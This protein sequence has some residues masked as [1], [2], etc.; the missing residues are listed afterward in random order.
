M[1]ENVPIYLITRWLSGEATPEERENLEIWLHQSPEN[2]ALFKEHETL[3]TRV[4]A[5]ERFK[6]DQ[7]LS[8]IN[9][10]I[11]AY[12]KLQSTSRSS[13]PFLLYKIAA[14]LIAV[15]LVGSLW[16]WF[17][18]TTHIE[19]QLS[20]T[21]I[22]TPA[23]SQQ[24]VVLSD[25]SLVQI[26]GQSKLYYPV[27]F[28]GNTREVH[29]TGEAYFKIAPD[30]QHPFI[31]RTG[32]FTTQV[33]GTAFNVKSDSSTVAVSVT[34]GVVKVFVNLDTVTLHPGEA[35]IYAKEQNSIVK[36]KADL[37]TALAWMSRSLI[38]QDETLGVVADKIYQLYGV[39][40]EFKSQRLKEVRVTGKFRKMSLEDIL[41]AIEFSTGTNIT[42]RD[43]HIIW[44]ETQHSTTNP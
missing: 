15:G 2:K 4:R 34:E 7:A 35:A 16:F 18:K 28:E 37:E 12:E 1:Q 26:N 40:S 19:N 27:D 41:L 8:K 5:S 25:S 11:D 43:K 30:K 9:Q 3:W 39:T 38:L 29:L 44:N 14:S 17:S 33:V 10:R 20:W 31:I 22:K 23:G 36:N 13:P 21:E 24:K 42:Y 32:D 6:S